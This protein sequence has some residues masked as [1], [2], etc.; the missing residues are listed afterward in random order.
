MIEIEN[1]IEIA[2]ES[3]KPW[4]FGRIGNGLSWRCKPK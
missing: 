4:I 1:M 2:K 3:I